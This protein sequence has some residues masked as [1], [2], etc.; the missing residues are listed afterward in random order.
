[1]RILFLVKAKNE[2][3]VKKEFDGYFFFSQ[4]LKIFNTL[5]AYKYH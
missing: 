2:K 1:M 5:T 3:N 4:N